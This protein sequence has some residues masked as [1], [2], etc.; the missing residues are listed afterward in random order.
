MNAEQVSLLLESRGGYKLTSQP[1]RIDGIEF[2]GD[3]DAVLQG[4][5]DERGL[6]L[7]VDASALSLK[8][9]QRRL[10]AACVALARTKSMRPT[11]LV[12]ITEK[13]PDDL[14]VA[15]LEALCRLIVIPAGADAEDCL[16][17]LLRLELPQEKVVRSADAVLQEELGGDAGDPFVTALIKAVRKGPSDVERT[18][19]EQI[20]RA[21]KLT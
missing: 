1:M 9:V 15:E 11:S 4:P 6:V 12:L 7:V 17:S 3:F 14:T 5:N 8:T 19:R 16:R 21:A 18:V 13:L 10:K 20:D 2:S